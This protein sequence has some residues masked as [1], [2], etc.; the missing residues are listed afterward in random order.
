MYLRISPEEYLAN[1]PHPNSVVDLWKK[2]RELAN[3]YQIE[4]QSF[5]Y[6]RGFFNYGDENAINTESKL[7][8]EDQKH[9][10]S[11][12]NTRRP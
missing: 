10:F 2:L 7:G 9:L 11:A 1:F 3:K 12:L 8:D 4:E 5:F 6:Y